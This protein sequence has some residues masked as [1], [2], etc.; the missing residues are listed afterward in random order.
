MKLLDFLQV[1]IYIYVETYLNKKSQFQ[2]IKT[3]LLKLNK[4]AKRRNK[5][6]NIVNYEGDIKE[7]KVITNIDKKRLGFRPEEG[8]NQWSRSCQNSGE[9]RRQ[10]IVVKDDNISKLLKKG[11][12]LNSKTKMYEKEVV[13]TEKGKKKKVIVK[14]VKLPS[15]EGKFIILYL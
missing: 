4:I 8:M 13:I 6:N 3:M 12:K 14:A 9:Q 5:V 7:I 2:K 10:P 1:L 11:Y 15:E